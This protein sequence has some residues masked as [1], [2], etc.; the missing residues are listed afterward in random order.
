MSVSARNKGR[1]VPRARLAPSRWATVP[2]VTYLIVATQVPLI[3]TLY[4]S[5][6]SWNLLYPARPRRFVGLD[7]FA[8]ILGDST[9]RTA[10]GNT[11]IF[12]IVP[13]VLT[14]LIGLGLALLVNRLRWGRGLAYSLL[15]APFLIMEAVSPIIWK[16]MI[17]NPIYG[18]LNFG[19][20]TVGLGTIDLIATDPKAAI[21]IMIVWQWSPFMMLILLAGLQ[22]VPQEVV[23][24]ARIDGANRWQQFRHI[25]L[26][27]L[28]PLLT[29]GMLIE[30]ILILPV[31]GPIYV[32]TYGGPGNASTNLMFAVYRVLTEQYEVGRAAAGG[33]ITAV[34]TTIVALALL[35]YI[36]PT[37]DRT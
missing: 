13:A 3:A 23:E 35:A 36:R 11:V 20:S 21:I 28:L 17:L 29:V 27:H 22:S 9:F 4:F 15:F 16:T 37:M 30:A 19:L 7:N 26:P 10:I 6:H 24:A 1:A 8:F 33:L 31:F 18:L 25:T 34:M 5:L 14:T 12:T 2:A 32:G